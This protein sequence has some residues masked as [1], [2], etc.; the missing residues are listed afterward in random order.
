LTKPKMESLHTALHTVFGA[1]ISVAMGYA[2]K[3]EAIQDIVSP[4]SSLLIAISAAVMGELIRN[5]I[6]DGRPFGLDIFITGTGILFFLIVKMDALGVS[7]D[8]LVSFRPDPNAVFLSLLLFFWVA[9]TSFVGLLQ[10]K[11]S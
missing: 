2:M 5:K 10:R 6:V 11:K 7:R 1:A 3:F 9:S 4:A 8:G